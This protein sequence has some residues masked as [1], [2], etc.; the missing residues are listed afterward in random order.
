M[1]YTS[2]HTWNVDSGWLVKHVRIITL[3]VFYGAHGEFSLDD[4]RMLVPSFLVFFRFNPIAE[5]GNAKYTGA[6][7]LE[8][9]L[10]DP[11][12]AFISCIGFRLPASLAS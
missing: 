6:S 5:I 2:F 1:T 3:T 7:L 9:F 10:S 11:S 12:A 4:A 8:T